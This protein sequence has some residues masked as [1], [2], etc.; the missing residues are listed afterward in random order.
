MIKLLTYNKVT[1]PY[2]IKWI[3]KEIK[4]FSEPLILSTFE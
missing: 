4:L 1:Y 3:D 2:S